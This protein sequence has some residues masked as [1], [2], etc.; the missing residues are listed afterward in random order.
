MKQINFINAGE[1]IQR[2]RREKTNLLSSTDDWQLIVDLE[3]QL[4]F[5]RHIAVTSLRPDL[6]L[7]SDNTK[8]CIIWELCHGRNILLSLMR[9]RR[10]NTKNWSNNVNKSHGIYIMT[11]VEVG[12]RGFAGQ[13]LGRAL[14]KIGIVG[15]ARVRA[16][17]DITNTVLKASKWIWLKRSEL[18]KIR[19]HITHYKSILS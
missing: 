16:L 13:S 12:C 3:T 19:R 10:P 7:Y 5:P 11:P 18:W 9:G 1:K 14:A 17:K 4:K 8:Q 6:I 15:A 2:K